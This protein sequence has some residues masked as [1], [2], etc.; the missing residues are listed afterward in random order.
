MAPLNPLSI[1]SVYLELATPW[2]R[3]VT[4]FRVQGSAGIDGATAVA[5]GYINAIKDAVAPNCVFDKLRYRGAG[6]N[7]SFPVAFTPVVGT[8][9]TNLTQ[10]MAA[11]FVS[12]TGRSAAGRRCRITQFG[13]PFATNDPQF[14]YTANELGNMADVLTFLNTS[15]P[16]LVAIDGFGVLWNNYINYGVNAYFQ[17]KARR[18]G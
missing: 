9:G 12:F 2:G 1:P 16:A 4:Q 7:L 14:R 13:M 11:T 10:S 8:N 5:T 17:R 3:H 15:N 6:S 18:A